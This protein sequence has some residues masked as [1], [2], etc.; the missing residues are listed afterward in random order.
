MI[1]SVNYTRIFLLVSIF[2]LPILAKASFN[3]Q[4]DEKRLHLVMRTIGDEL[5][6]SVGDTSSRV[7]P[8]QKEE[9][10]YTISFS[11]PLAIDPDGLIDIVDSVL[12]S[13]ELTLDYVT[14]VVKCDTR[15]VVYGYA[16]L[17]VSNPGS[18]ACRGRGLPEDCYEI[19]ITTV[20][21]VDFQTDFLGNNEKA[22]SLSS[23]LWLIPILL[24]LILAGILVSR[25]SPEEL[26]PNVFKIG[27]YI[28]DPRKMTLAIN[29]SVHD[30]SNK[31]S[32][33][34]SLLHTHQN[35]AV[36]RE[37]ILQKVWGDEGDYIGRTLDVFISKLR[38]KLDGDENV[39]IVN[40][41]G[42][43]Y[44]LITD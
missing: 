22:N 5:L 26:D 29:G 38:K 11:V 33:L 32:D 6:K 10:H 41:R 21:D 17:P 27:S 14:E 19:I 4:L 1:F 7:L 36:E 8:I 9:N 20:G 39:K 23:I 40:I 13:A 37:I 12:V 28:F 18:Q 42:V 3:D 30:L 15:E 31:E 16:M 34:L 44:K 35:E 24:L 43:G 25:K 2:C